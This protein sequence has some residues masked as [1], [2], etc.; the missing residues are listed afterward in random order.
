M[1]MLVFGGM[2]WEMLR[3]IPTYLMSAMCENF[4]Q[5]EGERSRQLL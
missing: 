3:A 4:L 1:K 2:G 5:S